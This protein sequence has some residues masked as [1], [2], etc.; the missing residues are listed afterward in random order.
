M[1]KLEKSEYFNLLAQ[2]QRKRDVHIS[3]AQEKAEKKE[4][5]ID[6]AKGRQLARL[7]AEKEKKSDS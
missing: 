3:E 6:A 5:R 4:A 1:A 2:V 7:E